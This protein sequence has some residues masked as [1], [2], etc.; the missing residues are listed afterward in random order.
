MTGRTPA[1]CILPST[2]LLNFCS[3]AEWLFSPLL[4]NVVLIYINRAKEKAFFF[5]LKKLTSFQELVCF[6]LVTLSFEIQ[7][8]EAIPV[9]IKTDT[10]GFDCNVTLL[11]C[12]PPP[13][14]LIAARMGW[15]VGQVA[16]SLLADPQSHICGGCWCF[17][18]VWL[19]AG[20]PAR[21]ASHLMKEI[22]TW[23]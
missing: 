19:V 9:E 4:D 8:R 14:G 16:S 21:P 3:E 11:P 17:R 23:A 13:R 1:S 20:L 2:G 5:F 22:E 7:P 15:E 10:R 12:S 6:S 18:G